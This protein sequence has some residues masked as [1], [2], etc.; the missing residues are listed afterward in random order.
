M[1]KMSRHAEQIGSLNL[2]LIMLRVGGNAKESRAV[3]N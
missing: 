3:A 2:N 1:G